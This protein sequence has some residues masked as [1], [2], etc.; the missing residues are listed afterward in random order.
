MSKLKQNFLPWEKV[1]Q[2]LAT[3]V[4]FK[5]LL[6]VNNRSRGKNLA[7]LVTLGLRQRS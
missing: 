5:E 3:F 6:E 7:N 4:I 1:A 2:N